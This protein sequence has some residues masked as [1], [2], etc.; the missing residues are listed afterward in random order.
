MTEME[1]DYAGRIVEF[2][3]AKPETKN[4]TQEQL[5][6]AF[7]LDKLPNTDYSITCDGD[8]EPFDSWD[9]YDD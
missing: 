2:A 9:Y 4:M 5:I 8:S 1:M 6:S 3:F 7:W